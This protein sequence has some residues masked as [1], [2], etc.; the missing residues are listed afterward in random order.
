MAVDLRMVAMALKISNDLERMG[1]YATNI[2]KRVR[3]INVHEPIKPLITIPLMAEICG[4]WSRTCS[5]PISSGTP[6]RR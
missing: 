3:R 6:T 1:D 4:G 5:M 2:A